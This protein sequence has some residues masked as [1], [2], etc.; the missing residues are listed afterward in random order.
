MAEYQAI[1]VDQADRV[2]TITLNRPE[3]FNALTGRM[4]DEIRAALEDARTDPRVGA[5]VL[6]G[7]GRAFCSGQDLRAIEDEA[8]GTDIG[9]FVRHHLRHHFNPMVTA[10]R[11][12]PKP[13]LAA[14]NGVAAGAGMSLAIACDIRLGSERASFMQAFSRVGLVPDT[15]STYLLPEIVGTARALELAWSAR[16]VGAEEALALGLLTIQ[17]GEEVLLQEAHDLAVRLAKGPALATAMAKEAMVGAAERGLEATLD[18]EADLQGQCIVSEDFAEGVSAFLEKREP[19]F[20][21]P[22]SHA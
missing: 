19:R 2:A 9:D 13:V 11:R 15:G 7:A 12:L 5:V 1:I 6:T 10:I 21:T 17:A 4:S 20:G 16:R 14:V 8:T 22:A 3:S 18:L